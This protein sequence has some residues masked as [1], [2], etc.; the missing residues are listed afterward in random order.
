MISDSQWRK[1]VRK[2]KEGIELRYKMRVIDEICDRVATKRT[3]SGAIQMVSAT[4]KDFQKLLFDSVC[5]GTFPIELLEKI[6]EF[7]AIN[8]TTHMRQPDAY[9][10]VMTVRNILFRN[11][12]MAAAIRIMRGQQSVSA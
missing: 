11:A 4:E 6:V 12:H 10:V 2:F 9:R 8:L 5:N 7:T 1:A 3:A